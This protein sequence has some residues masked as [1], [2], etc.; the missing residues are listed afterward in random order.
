MIPKLFGKLMGKDRNSNVKGDNH[1]ALLLISLFI[2]SVFNIQALFGIAP[3][4]Y[5]IVS[6][7]MI[8]IFSVLSWLDEHKAKR[9]I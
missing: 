8:S 6:F 3:K 2:P 1:V 9:R 4:D 5:L 7:L